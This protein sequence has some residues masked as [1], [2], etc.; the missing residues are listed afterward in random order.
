MLRGFGGGVS[1]CKRFVSF[2]FQRG[3][4]LPKIELKGHIDGQSQNSSRR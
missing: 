3:Y 1:N 2:V 4:G